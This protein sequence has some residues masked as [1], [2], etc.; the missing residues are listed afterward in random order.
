MDDEPLPFRPF[1]KFLSRADLVELYKQAAAKEQD[2]RL[3]AM[4]Q[5]R[6]ETLQK[7]M[8]DSVRED[9]NLRATE[10]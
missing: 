6:L 2:P 9:F 7:V 3:K 1:A 10:S 8:V 5:I 4:A